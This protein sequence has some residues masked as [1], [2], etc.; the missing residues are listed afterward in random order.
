MLTE[1]LEFN[2]IELPKMYKMHQEGED[3]LKEWLEFLENPDSKE[4]RSYMKRNENMKEAREKLDK[5]SKNERVRRLAELRQKAL[6]DER[7]AE[8]TGY[9]KGLEDGM[10]RGMDCNREKIKEIV[11]KMKKEKIDI[12]LIVRITGLTKEEIEEI[13]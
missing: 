6:M 9:C 3:K 12:E 5:M 4:V 11:K 7:E 8:Y 13:V 1:D 2:I 10:K